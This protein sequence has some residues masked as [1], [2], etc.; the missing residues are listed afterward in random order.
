MLTRTLVLS[1]AASA[2]VLLAAVAPASAEGCRVQ[3]RLGPVTKEGGSPAATPQGTGIGSRV[4]GAPAA[5]A[6]PATYS[7]NFDLELTGCPA[8]PGRPNKFATA[9]YGTVEFTYKKH[10][11]KGTVGGGVAADAE[12]K[13]TQNWNRPDKEHT[14]TTKLVAND[15][16]GIFEVSEVAVEK[17]VCGCR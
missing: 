16:K 10:Y 4:K 7:I 11:L 5:G 15:D 17:A 1:T 8:S 14:I 13:G 2:A 3:T 9:A 6:T 12:G